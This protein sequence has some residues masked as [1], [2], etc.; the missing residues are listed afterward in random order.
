MR[1]LIIWYIIIY[2]VDVFIVDT[3]VLLEIK[4]E[5]Y[6]VSYTLVY[7]QI[8]EDSMYLNSNLD[9]IYHIMSK[10]CSQYFNNIECKTHVMLHKAAST[11]G[12]IIAVESFT[13]PYIIQGHIQR[14]ISHILVIIR[15]YT[16]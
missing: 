1:E 12:L 3:H 5:F 14:F 15:R 8:G 2:D 9:L 6:K 7:Y 11:R 13:D 10:R 16:Q 4:N